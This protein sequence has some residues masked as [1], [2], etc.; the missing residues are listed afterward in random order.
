[1]ICS[2]KYSHWL[3][4]LFQFANYTLT[5]YLVY[6]FA[7]FET[8]QTKN[9]GTPKTSIALEVL[10]PNTAYFF[11]VIA[12]ND[13]GISL[14]SVMSSK[15]TTPSFGKNVLASKNFKFYVM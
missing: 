1:M 3:Q 2:N 10:N 15:F 11:R 12:V 6:D 8:V 5:E 4:F 13:Q 9:T 14:P 7:D